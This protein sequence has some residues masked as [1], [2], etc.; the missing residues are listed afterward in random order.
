MKARTAAVIAGG[1]AA[2][3]VAMLCW[4]VGW[5]WF[6]VDLLKFWLDLILPVGG[7]GLGAI[8]GAGFWLAGRLVKRPGTPELK[9]T[10]A[11]IALAAAAGIRF[12]GYWSVEFGSVPLHDFMSFGDYLQMTL[13]HARVDFSQGPRALGSVNVGPFG[14]LMGA[15]QS[16][17]YALGSIVAAEALP[18]AVRCKRHGV[19][20]ER[21]WAKVRATAHS[22]A[23]FYQALPAG[24]A[25]RLA[26]LDAADP[27][28][29]LPSEGGVEL[30]YRLAECD[31]CGAAALAE[32]GRV[33]N[34]RVWMPFPRLTRVTLFDR[35]RAAPAP[36]SPPVMSGPRGFGRRTTTL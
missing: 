15:I 10:A 6:E 2:H 27:G 16:A 30:H 3:L 23:D 12:L 24:P 28:S 13:G 31:D 9:W 1:I 32:S 21:R 14:Y 18:S 26:A 20:R 17:C 11:V 29:D 5:R 34:G 36:P 7:M 33:H 19:M 4:Y 22:F 35:M 25:E 8:G